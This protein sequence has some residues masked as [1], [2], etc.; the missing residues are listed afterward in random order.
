MKSLRVQMKQRNIN[1]MVTCNNPTP[2][3]FFRFIQPAHKA[4]AIEKYGRILDQAIEIC[5]NPNKKLELNNVKET[6][7]VRN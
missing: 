7:D 4:R 6:V 5:K 3:E 1:W 2:I